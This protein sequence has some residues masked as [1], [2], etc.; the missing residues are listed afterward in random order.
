MQ[1]SWLIASRRL[2]YAKETLFQTIKHMKITQSS[3]IYIFYTAKI[4]NHNFLF[5]IVMLNI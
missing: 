2:N 5:Q 3:F 1:L 4:T